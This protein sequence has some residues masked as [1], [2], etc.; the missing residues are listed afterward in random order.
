VSAGGWVVVG[1][2]LVCLLLVGGTASLM[3]DQ[4]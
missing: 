4:A 1:L 3:P 2:L